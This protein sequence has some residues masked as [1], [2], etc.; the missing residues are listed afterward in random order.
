MDLVLPDQLWRQ[1][2]RAV[3]NPIV[4]VL[5]RSRQFRHGVVQQLRCRRQRRALLEV[6]ELGV[7]DRVAVTAEVR[8]RSVGSDDVLLE[9]RAKAQCSG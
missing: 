9:L 1:P 4:P 2:H 7:E 3:R 5:R 6:A 8:L